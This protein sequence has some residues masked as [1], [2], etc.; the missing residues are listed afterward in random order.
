MD[1]IIVL[2][3]GALFGFIQF[4]LRRRTLKPLAEGN[5]PQVGVLFFLKLAVPLVLLIG[6]AL[7]DT[8]LLPYAAASFC[9]SSIVATV[10]NHLIT[11]K[12]KDDL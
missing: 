9:L 1:I 4:L 12:K 3:V 7:V 6:C 10:A 8:A 11:N 2:I 5:P